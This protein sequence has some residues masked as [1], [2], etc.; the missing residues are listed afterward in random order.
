MDVQELPAK[1]LIKM[2]KFTGSDPHPIILNAPFIG[3]HLRTQDDY[4]KMLP[5]FN[6]HSTGYPE[7]A[8]KRGLQ[9]AYLA[10]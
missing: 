4:L 3:V 10:C 5:N 6:F 8:Q 7:Q 9:Y 2:A 1:V